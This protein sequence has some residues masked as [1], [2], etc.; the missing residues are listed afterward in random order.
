MWWRFSQSM[1]RWYDICFIF[2]FS[3]SEN[4]HAISIIQ[5]GKFLFVLDWLFIHWSFQDLQICLH[6]LGSIL[7]L[8]ARKW[9]I[10]ENFWWSFEEEGFYGIKVIL[11]KFD[12][13]GH[14]D[15]LRNSMKITLFWAPLVK[16]GQVCFR[17]EL[18]DFPF[19]E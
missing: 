16:G 9:G 4:W 3:F 18:G 10:A 1:I 8:F 5:N 14:Q 17:N 2:K 15:L 19:L 11:L 6:V 7:F 13:E 12:I